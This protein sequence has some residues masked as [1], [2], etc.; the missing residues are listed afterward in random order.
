MEDI[1]EIKGPHGIGYTTSSKVKEEIENL[2]ETHILDEW[3]VRKEPCAAKEAS[4][5]MLANSQ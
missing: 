1:H 3:A 4:Y 5:E 2:K